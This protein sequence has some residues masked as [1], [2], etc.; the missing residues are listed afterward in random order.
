VTD[1]L[2]LPTREL[3]AQAHS[4]NARLNS[5]R[6]TYVVNRNLNFTNVCSI[7]CTFCGFAR[8]SNDEMAYSYTPREVVKRLSNTPWVS[9]VCMQGGI[10]RDMGY[11]DYLTLLRE[12]KQ[13][14]PEIHVHAFSPM[15]IH[16]MHRKS[17]REHRDILMEL[18]DAG[19][20]SIPGTAAEILVDRVRKEV[21]GNK[22]SSDE[23]ENIIRTAHGVGLPSTATIMFGHVE[24][25]ED[26][27]EHLERIK[28]IQLDTGGFTEFVPLAFIPYKNRLGA[29]IARQTGDRTFERFE[30]RS[31]ARAERLYPLCRLFFG[32]LIPNLQ[33]SWVKLGVE[34]AIQSLEWGCND[35]GGTLY[36]E[37][38]TQ[39][40]GGLHG[41]CLE[42]EVI[43]K[44]L[45]RAGKKPRR[46]TTTYG[47]AETVQLT[48]P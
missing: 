38:I 16:H 33:T 35:F 19:L 7:G 3:Q 28:N 25:W 15:E 40:S 1:W 24:T 27:L 47:A 21:S 30:A 12:V 10:P 20:G 26:I 23:W 45:R 14:F 2:T 48:V 39:A 46:R 9:E 22:L 4:L 6:V 13:A 32:D 36:E 44:A 31:Q 8:S 17:G 5:D 42:P 11:A 43:E 41:E 37:S 29:R 34:Q 18:K